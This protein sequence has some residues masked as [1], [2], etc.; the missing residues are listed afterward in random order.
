MRGSTQGGRFD[1]RYEVSSISEGMS[2]DLYDPAGTVFKWFVY[3]PGDTSVDPVYDV[4][5]PQHGGRMWKGPY[6]VPVLGVRFEQGE[7]VQNKRGLYTTDI[8]HAVLNIGQLDKVLFDFGS[9][10]NA[11]DA[12]YKDRF[13]WRGELWEPTKLWARG[14]I[15][16]YRTVVS[17]DAM[18]V[19]DDQIVD[20][21]FFG[22]E[23]PPANY[24]MGQYGVSR[25]NVFPAGE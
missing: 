10:G 24:G 1:I 2:D 11:I 12:H 5:D 20:D 21:V 14:S 16:N 17:M 22:G 8:L 3:D 15:S 9:Q 4:G 19:M 25:Y 6:R 23:I 7:T 18:Q 13:L